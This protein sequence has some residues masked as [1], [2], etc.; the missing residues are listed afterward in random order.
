LLLRVAV[1]LLRFCGNVHR[2]GATWIASL[3]R[4]DA[5]GR[6]LARDGSHNS[7]QI[8]QLAGL[9]IAGDTIT[10]SAETRANSG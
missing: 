5:S 2:C 1:L 8:S 10:H 6:R 3:L 4:N 7:V 9:S